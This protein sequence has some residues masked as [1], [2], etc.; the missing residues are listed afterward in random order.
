MLKDFLEKNFELLDDQL[1]SHL[2]HFRKAH[3]FLVIYEDILN[4]LLKEFKYESDEFFGMIN[5]LLNLIVEYG[6][7][8]PT[9]YEQIRQ[10]L[11]K[12]QLQDE[13][14]FVVADKATSRIFKP[15]IQF[16]S[17]KGLNR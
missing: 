16:C 3:S 8:H 2:G 7:N 17:T 11:V 13:N 1:I 14:I 4:K 6:S 10:V 15:L 5:S 12:Y 9:S